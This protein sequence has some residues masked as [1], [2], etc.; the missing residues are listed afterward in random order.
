MSFFA[1]LTPHTYTPTAGLDILNVGWLDEGRPFPVAPTSKTFQDALRELCKH[2]IILHRGFHLCCYCPGKRQDRSG[3]GQIR[4]LG[5]KGIWFAAPTLVHHYV[6][7]HEYSP[8][9]D[10]VDAVLSPV[11]VG[12]DYGWYPDLESLLGKNRRRKPRA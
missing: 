6:V 2:P 8:P 4:V 5:R 12:T 10:F 11:A 3:N 7:V 9:A 1:D